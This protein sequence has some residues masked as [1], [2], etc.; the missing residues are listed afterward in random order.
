MTRQPEHRNIETGIFRLESLDGAADKQRGLAFASL[1][2]TVQYSIAVAA[3]AIACRLAK[4]IATQNFRP[5]CYF[6][7]LN[8]L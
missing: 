7:L 5:G 2:S 6:D 8:V 1:V 3:A 4:N